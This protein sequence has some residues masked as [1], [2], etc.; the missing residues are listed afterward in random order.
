MKLIIETDE[1]ILN[2]YIFDEL[3]NSLE[4]MWEKDYINIWLSWWNS[5]LSFYKHLEENSH[6]IDKS[7]WEKINFGFVDERIVT[8]DDNYSNYWFLKGIFLDKLVEKKLIKDSQIKKIYINSKNI[9]KDYTK[10]FPFIDIWLFWVGE[11]WH[12]ASIFPKHQIL[13]DKSNSYLQINDS[14]KLPK[15]RITISPLYLQSINTCFVFFIWEKK[16]KAFENFLDPGIWENQCPAK[17]IYNCQN[18][19]II[20]NI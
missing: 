3:V 12:I 16:L 20:S 1:K 14:P 10:S 15:N 5:I 7:I 17:L 9:S 13:K 2:K 18:Q 11:D 4:K 8:F 19:I 6:L